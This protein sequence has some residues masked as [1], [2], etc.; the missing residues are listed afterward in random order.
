[1]SKKIIAVCI[2]LALLLGTIVGAARG[3]TTASV[4]I[5]EEANIRSGAGTTFSVV[6]V[7]HKGE[8]YEAV[9]SSKDTSG[10]TW[11]KI[12]VDTSFGFVA[13]WLVTYA[14][15]TASPAS[16]VV[17]EPETAAAQPTTTTQPSSTRYAVIVEDGTSL[18]SG[19]G[20]AF[21]RLTT[22]KAQTSLRILSESKDTGGK[23]WYK[24]DC[25][26]LKLK[27]TSGYVASWVVKVQAVV[28]PPSAPTTFT[29]SALLALW[30]PRLPQSTKT[31]DASNL[32]S[33]PSVTF[34]RLGVL[35]SGTSI[36]ITAYS[37]NEQKETW[38]RVTAAEKTGWVYAA[39]L[40]YS[41]RIPGI[42]L[43]STVGKSLTS[44]AP[45]TR[46][47]ASPFAA[48]TDGSLPA[49]GKSLVGVATDGRQVF[50][51]LSSELSSASWIAM[52]EGTVV[53]GTGPGGDVCSLTGIELVSSNGWTGIT[54]HIVGDKSGLSIV[55]GHVPERLEISLP[56][57]VQ[58]AQPNIAG[59]PTKQVSAV[60]V[61]AS[62]AGFVSNVVIYLAGVDIGVKQS[63]SVSTV[64]LAI[65]APGST[66]PSKAVFLRSELLSSSEE[67]FFA[68]GA[69]FV[70]LADVA[71]A[72]DVLLS[73]DAANQ[74]TSL[75]LGDRQYVLKEGLRTLKIAQGSNHWSEEMVVAPRILS[76][77]LYVPVA[78]VAHVFGLEASG[79]ALRVYLDPIISSIVLAGTSD[80]ESGSITITSTSDLRLTKTTE[81]DYCV[82]QLEGVAAS[83][84]ADNRA[85]S[86][87][88]DV[89]VRQRIN[90]VPPSVELRLHATDSSADVQSPGTGIYVIMLLDATK[91]KL[92]GKKVVLDPGHGCMSSTGYFDAGAIGS[93]GTK[94][95]SVNLSIALKAKALLEAD[96][97]L[98]VVTRSD[99]SSKDN[100]DLTKRA[101]IANSSGADL[102]LSIHQNATDAGPSMGGTE[103]HYW[104][105]QSKVFA[106][107]V[108]K[109]LVLA[110]GTTDRG[111]EKTSLYLVS[112]IDTMPAA[113]VECAFISNSEEEHLLRE[114]AFQQKVAQDIAD[115]IVEYFR[116]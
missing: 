26:S 87:W 37:M 98:V 36:V 113:L 15:A 58:S 12:R 73:W 96:G 19:A 24:V 115:A 23:I 46:L 17:S 38:C 68:E 5:P 34:D 89:A 1:M 54:M 64:Q 75:T 109:H 50:L 14:P 61:W 44:V 91:G 52:A 101:Q 47:V 99:D 116:K 18:R 104:F 67:T 66:E 53:G 94:E 97:A 105:D 79:D 13:G 9:G 84:I 56:W 4:T 106:T 3:D 107:L 88:A 63:T 72:Y 11:Y 16:P 33:G 92:Q 65:S 62:S 31:V 114:D 85:L 86:T 29:A 70:P 95:S 100:P 110:L 30:Q 55:R 51:Q 77:L 35:P 40:S 7:A 112:H 42:L 20:T 49:A 57:L 25:T 28:A 82:F 43:A 45:S 27:Q 60:K 39:L 10:R 59:V 6:R 71:N 78:T 81:G 41:E 111:T 93:S 103:T 80:T 76:G 83:A 74:Q 102:F 8:K 48:T 21:V 69:T 32:R 2:I 108:Q 90:D 22:M